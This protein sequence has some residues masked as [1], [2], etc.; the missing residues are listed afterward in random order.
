[1][2]TTPKRKSARSGNSRVADLDNGILTAID[3]E[4]VLMNSEQVSD[5]P[6]TMQNPNV[7]ETSLPQGAKV[8][9]DFVIGSE[10]VLMCDFQEVKENTL[11]PPCLPN[12]NPTQPLPNPRFSRKT[13][14]PAQLRSLSCR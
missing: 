4:T 5:P 8:S 10:T 14:I 1:M 6:I 3:S 2:K 9:L 13:V 7:D 12:P 11:P